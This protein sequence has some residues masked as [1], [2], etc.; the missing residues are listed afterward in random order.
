[1]SSFILKILA[2]IS[3]FF[4]H[5]GYTLYSKFSSFNYIGRLAFPIFAF[6]LSEG[7]L[8][9]KSKKNYLFR[10][11]L[12]AL[13]SQ[14][15]FMLFCSMFRTGF[16]LN[17]FFTLCIGILAIW[18]YEQLKEKSK[19]FGIFFVICFSFIADV[20]HAD[21]GSWGVWVIFLFY[22]FKENKW[23]MNLS[24]IALVLLKYLP[25]YLSTG[26][27]LPYLLLILST[28]F[29]L[30]I[31]NLYNG[32]KGPDSRYFLYTFYPLHVLLLYL[33]HTIFIH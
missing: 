11:F 26:F 27:A 17:I 5:F 23:L 30:C 7:Y 24:F 2:A 14:L 13:I 33:F 19:G 22:L 21:Y 15:P 18:G 20:T 12:F 1:M 16:Y 10:L 6:Q 4:D 29:S 28:C 3:M 25:A 32:K 8:H 9:T 31:I